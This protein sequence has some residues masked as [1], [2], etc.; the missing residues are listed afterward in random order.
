MST[1]T[2]AVSKGLP[3]AEDLIRATKDGIFQIASQEYS[4]SV[5]RMKA[6]I[7]L[8]E[9]GSSSFSMLVTFLGF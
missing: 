9:T 2:L 1:R 8:F 4:T 3:H 7:W 6:K 5:L